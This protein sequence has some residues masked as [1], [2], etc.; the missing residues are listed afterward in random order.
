[1]AR[2]A[3]DATDLSAK[4]LG[5]I[6]EKKRANDERRKAEVALDAANKEMEALSYAVSHDLRAPLRAID[7]FARILEEDYAGQLGDA[8]KQAIDVI[9]D[10]THRMGELIG[11]IL[12]YSRLGRREIRASGVDMAGLAREAFQ[13]LERAHPGR[14]LDFRLGPLP[15]ARADRAMV[16]EVL[17]HLLSNAIKFTAPRPA[18]I[19]E[20]SGEIEG[21]EC[22]YHIKDN[23][24][25]FDMNYAGKLFRVLQ[26]LHSTKEFEG[27]G[28]GLAIVQRI[29]RRHGGRVWAEGAVGAG[30]TFWFALPRERKE[31]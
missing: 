31:A 13:E 25:G 30:A 3:S 16:R 28:V 12:A 5:A 23:G 6:V 10:N 21:N 22:I 2:D 24:V 19:I 18:A 29:V 8:G 27:T 7:G 9:R 15:P 11:G 20:L 26:R 1:M 4:L 14:G 17:L